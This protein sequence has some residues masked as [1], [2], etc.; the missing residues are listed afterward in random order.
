MKAY[1]L[2]LL[3]HTCTNKVFD[4]IAVSENR[5]TKQTSLT[6]TINLKNN[7]IK[8]TCTECSAGDMLLYIAS[9]LFYK[10]RPDLNIYKANQLESTF[11]E[12]INPQKSNIVIGCLYKHPNMDVLDFKNLNQI[13]EILS[14][15]WKQVFLLGDFNINLLNYNDNQPTYDF[16]DSI[17]SNY[18]VLYIFHPTRITSHSKTLI[19]NIFPNYISHEII[20]GKITAT[21]SDHLPPFSFVPNILAN[22]FIQK[23]NVYERDWS[24]CKQENF[25]LGYFDKS[26]TDLLQIDQQNVNLSMNTS[27]KID[28]TLDTHAPLKKLINTN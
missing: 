11:V 12:I 19:D 3:F 14:K 24:K 21:I 13:F 9:Y 25:I 23:S 26:S 22:L 5:I 28:S 27:N 18:F 16:L 20:S 6:S 10:P 4:I 7:A 8:F 17:A 15:E 2:V 1:D